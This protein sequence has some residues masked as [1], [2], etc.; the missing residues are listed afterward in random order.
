VFIEAN[1][2]KWGLAPMQGTLAPP[3]AYGSERGSIL[4]QSGVPRTP[5]D[6]SRGE[7]IP[8]EAP[9]IALDHTSHVP[10]SQPPEYSSLPNQNTMANRI[11]QE[12]REHDNNDEVDSG[13]ATSIDN[14]NDVG[15][16]HSV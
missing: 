8:E 3:P 13:D 9:L 11:A 4:L 2:K 7:N 16:Q 12:E 1:V 15:Q 5:V 14:S 10:H 6:R